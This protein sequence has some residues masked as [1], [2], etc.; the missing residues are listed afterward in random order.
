M[1]AEN[2]QAVLWYPETDLWAKLSGEN[3]SNPK[4]SYEE[5]FIKLAEQRGLGDEAKRVAAAVVK[6]RSRGAS[7]AGSP[8][9]TQPDGRVLGRVDRKKQAKERQSIQ[10]KSPADLLAQ[11]EVQV[12][13]QAQA[14]DA[15]P[16]AICSQYPAGPF[17][18]DLFS[19]SPQSPVNQPINSHGNTRTHISGRLS[20]IQSGATGAFPGAV[21]AVAPPDNLAGIVRR[22]G[23]ETGR[24]AEVLLA[25]GKSYEGTASAYTSNGLLGA[26]GKVF[27]RQTGLGIYGFSITGGIPEDETGGLVV[28]DQ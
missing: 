6:R 17:D 26:G 21:A 20:E 8:D 10:S 12:R 7:R 11:A 14:Q 1:T 24:L 5:E 13:A 3:E 28:P 25:V 16:E 23:N 2:V 27:E 19:D 18:S 22:F 4:S 9:V 15:V